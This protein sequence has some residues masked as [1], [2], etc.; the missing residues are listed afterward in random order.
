MAIK[1]G[2]IIQGNI[3]PQTQLVLESLPKHFD[4][5]VLSTWDDETKIPA[6]NFDTLKNQ[7][8]IAPGFNNRNYQRYSTARGLEAA[9]AAGCDY[10]LKWR[11]DMLPTNISRKQLLEWA[12]FRPLQNIKSRIVMPAF[13]NLSV[14]PDCLSSIPDLFSFGHIEEMQKL[15]GDK[16]FNYQNQFNLPELDMVLLGEEIL[17]SSQFVDWYCPESELYTLYRH[18]LDP[19]GK[20]NLHHKHIATEYLR[21]IDYRV[22]GILWFG[23]SYGFRPVGAAWEHPWWTEKQWE[24]KSAQ[25]NVYG[26]T[27]KGLISKLKRK[28][29]KY[30]INQELKSQK[31]IWEINFQNNFD[32]KALEATDDPK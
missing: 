32:P 26:Y 15:W 7:K 29:S 11:T 19:I 3:R 31:K 16:T 2:C 12:Q 1:I 14:T 4:Y 18:Q 21:L 25:L 17:N 8:P 5:S 27:S 10:V 13:R 22:L 28:I 6:G 23:R 24:E 20:L 30:R 9:T